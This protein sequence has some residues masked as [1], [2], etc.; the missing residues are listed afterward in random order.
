MQLLPKSGFIGAHGEM[1]AKT[2]LG[3]RLRRRDFGSD[4]VIDEDGNAI[5]LR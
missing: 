3:R 1:G 5:S 4:G 2:H